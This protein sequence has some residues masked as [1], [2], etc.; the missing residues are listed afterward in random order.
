LREDNAVSKDEI[1]KVLCQEITKRDRRAD[2]VVEIYSQNHADSDHEKFGVFCPNYADRPDK[3]S[4]IC[5]KVRTECKNKEFSV[6]GK[7]Y[8]VRK[9]EKFAVWSEDARFGYEV[10]E[11]LR[12]VVA[13]NS[14]Y[15]EFN[16]R[17]EE[18]VIFA[19]ISRLHSE[20]HAKREDEITIV[21]SIV[22]DGRYHER[23]DVRGLRACFGRKSSF[24]YSEKSR[25]KNEEFEILC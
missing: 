13:H 25:F 12:A 20:I 19:E 10:V 2:E 11:V 1:V 5:D 8:S 17:R 15:K 22:S 7:N 14:H 18:S 24:V 21:P 3:I 9:N 23:F 16:V 4:P 6:R